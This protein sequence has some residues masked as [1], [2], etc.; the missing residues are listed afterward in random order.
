MRTLTAI[1]L[2]AALTPRDAV[3][4]DAP[5]TPVA[6]ADDTTKEEAS[7][8]RLVARFT[9]EEVPNLVPARPAAAPSRPPSKAKPKKA[10]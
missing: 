5:K 2:V 1:L 10:A 6:P 3:A 7:V 4:D 9:L 8:L